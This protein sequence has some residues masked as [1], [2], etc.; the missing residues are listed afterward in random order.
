[1]KYLFLQA[2]SVMYWIDLEVLYSSKLSYVYSLPSLLWIAKVGGSPFFS[3]GTEDN[4]TCTDL[5]YFNG[6]K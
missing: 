1:M 6:W 3:S 5:F 4:R 2:F